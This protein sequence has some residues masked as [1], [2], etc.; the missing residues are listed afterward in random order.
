MKHYFR[1]FIFLSI[2]SFN[3]AFAQKSVVLL[4]LNDCINCQSN[5]SAYFNDNVGVKQDLIIR[6]MYRVDSVDIVNL[7]NLQQFDF[8]LV[9][10][11]SVYNRLLDPFHKS[12][13]VYLDDKDGVVSKVVLKDYVS[14]GDDLKN[15]K[16]LCM[17]QAS[18]YELY[19]SFYPHS[20]VQSRISL[21]KFLLQP[22][23]GDSGHVFVAD[24][25]WLRLGYEALIGDGYME[26]YTQMLEINAYAPGTKSSIM[27]LDIDHEQ[28]SIL[29]DVSIPRYDTVLEATRIE[30]RCLLRKYDINTR[31]FTAIYPIQEGVLRKM[32]YY[33]TL[34]AVY[35]RKGVLYL[36]VK[37]LNGREYN[38]LAM[39]SLH[40]NKYYKFDGFVNDSLPEIYR[41]YDLSG[42][43]NQHLFS[44]SLTAIAHSDYI[45]DMESDR[46][47]RLPLEEKDL[48]TLYKMKHVFRTG[49]NTENIK[50]YYISDLM[51]RGD[52][53]DVLYA[54]PDG[55][56]YLST[57]KKGSANPLVN[58]QVA[59]KDGDFTLRLHPTKRRLLMLAKHEKCM[60]EVDY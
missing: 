42:I 14:T 6:E 51:D 48:E 4:D 1:Y 59:T 40:D 25:A 50:F 53:F 11:D 52:S 18:S 2:F 54:K 26:Y 13:V 58:K 49:G 31:Q 28:V 35:N 16:P 38:T 21:G 3:A 23:Q 33:I 43:F 15:Y 57:F 20:L 17:G 55:A 12:I 19:K 32:D 44:G 36:S 45:Y 30:K 7:F 10:S 27:G 60:E 37:Y 24:S 47:Y 34:G 22:L 8:E 46:R 9:F 29:Y 39:F 41:K 5:L 56:Y